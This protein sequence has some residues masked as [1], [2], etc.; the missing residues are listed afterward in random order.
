MTSL[1]IALYQPDIAGNTSLQYS[2]YFSGLHDTNHS[3]NCHGIEK[4]YHQYY[5][6]IPQI[7]NISTIHPT[8][9]V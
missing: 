7:L 1:R 5:E 9:S 3:G 8:N 2:V 6:V 4:Y